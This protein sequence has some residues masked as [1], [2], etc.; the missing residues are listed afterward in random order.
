MLSSVT[1]TIQWKESHGVCKLLFVFLV[2][3]CSRSGEMP[4][5]TSQLRHCSRRSC[6]VD[7]SPD[8]SIM[9][10]ALA[11][12][13]I[14]FFFW[15]YTLCIHSGVF[16]EQPDN[17]LD[18][19]CDRELIEL[20]QGIKFLGPLAAPLLIYGAQR[21]KILLHDNPISLRRLPCSHSG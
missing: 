12:W 8:W 20:P 21:K 6:R 1:S 13:P 17:C 18:A 15:V 2:P 9:A 11:L 7:D 10:P 5:M 19:A 3:G 16:C 4:G 14:H